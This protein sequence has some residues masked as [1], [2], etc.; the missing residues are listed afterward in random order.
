[1]FGFPRWKTEAT[2]GWRTL[3]AARA[4]RTNRRWVDSSPT[5]RTLITFNAT[6]HQRLTSIAFVFTGLV[7]RHRFL[8]HPWLRYVRIRSLPSVFRRSFQE[9]KRHKLGRYVYS[10]LSWTQPASSKGASLPNP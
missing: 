6:A 3:A 1:M 10:P 5:N 4:S 7:S 2:F 9:V 8:A